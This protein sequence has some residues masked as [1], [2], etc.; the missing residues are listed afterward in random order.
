MRY[1][2][3]LVGSGWYIVSFLL[4]ARVLLGAFPLSPTIAQLAAPAPTVVASS[5]SVEPAG[6]RSL[7]FELNQG[8]TDSQVKF[9]ARGRGYVVFLGSGETVLGLSTPDA[10]QGPRFA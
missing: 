10:S 5:S 3:A 8:Q 2:E 1:F 7:L 4:G 6:T 9:L